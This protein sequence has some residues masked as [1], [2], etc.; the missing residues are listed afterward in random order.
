MITLPTEL[1]RLERATKALEWPQLSIVEAQLVAEEGMRLLVELGTIEDG[2]P[3]LR[4]VHAQSLY[5]AGDHAGALA[6]IEVA[7]G[8]SSSPPWAA[9]PLG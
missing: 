2:E 1:R 7:A 8:P 4:L 6:A 9:E 5:A 3:L